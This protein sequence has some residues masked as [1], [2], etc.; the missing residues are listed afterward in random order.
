MLTKTVDKPLDRVN[1]HPMPV[2]TRC[3]L[4]SQVQTVIDKKYEGCV[5]GTCS[6][7]QSHPPPQIFQTY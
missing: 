3:P 6:D 7:P 1:C 4:H 5:K 2:T